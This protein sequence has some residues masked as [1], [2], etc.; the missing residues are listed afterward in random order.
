MNISKYSHEGYST[1]DP[2]REKKLLVHKI[3]I[4]KLENK[5]RKR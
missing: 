2:D 5:S 1:H 3:E 4:K